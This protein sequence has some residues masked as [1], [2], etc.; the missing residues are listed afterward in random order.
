MNVLLLQL[1]VI[2]GR[3]TC[4]VERMVHTQ[5]LQERDIKNTL[6]C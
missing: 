3:G 1:L 5:G 6:R 4:H 2:G